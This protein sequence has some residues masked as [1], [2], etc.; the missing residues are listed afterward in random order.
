MGLGS[1]QAPRGRRNSPLRA[2]GLLVAGLGIAAC[3][4]GDVSTSIPD[5]SQVADTDRDASDV[6]ADNPKPGDGASDDGPLDA[7]E[8][9][10]IL[11]PGC[12]AT[13]TPAAAA[14]PLVWETCGAGCKR[15]R[16]DWSAKVER[17]FLSPAIDAI[18]MTELGPVF[19]QYR[20]N[21]SSA[22]SFVTFSVV[23]QRLDGPVLATASTTQDGCLLEATLGDS[24]WAIASLSPSTG[25]IGVARFGW[26]EPRIP[27][28]EAKTSQGALALGPAG[29]HD[30]IVL[31]SSV[32]F[33]VRD[34]EGVAELLADG[35][36]RK[37]ALP[38]ESAVAW[39]G[40]GAA[41]RLA[42]PLGVDT[43]KADGTVGES[44][45]PSV[46][47]RAIA[48]RVDRPADRLVWVEAQET[49]DG[50]LAPTLWVRE[51]STNRLVAPLN[52]GTGRGAGP[53]VVTNGL[54]VAPISDT[55]VQ[56]VR[57]SDGLGW[58]MSMPSG[59][60]AIEP[61]WIDDEDVWVVVGDIKLKNFR[62]YPQAILRLSRAA[63]GPAS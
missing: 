45:V 55:T 47:R 39:R 54:V 44:I 11:V 38:I 17:A 25:A 49:L 53:F 2:V 41:V 13:P 19:L 50:W 31:S 27:I 32:D 48:V 36:L 23:L 63:L 37:F 46:G 10:S 28:Q 16:S 61:L 3:H 35:S 33:I 9:A 43:W 42:E 1:A 58:T 52:D 24:G 30:D 20:T 14:A 59:L 29:Y 15:S 4:S 57:L 21:W 12:A 18:R 26:K 51:A 6:R 56:I 7:S 8:T 34:P 60:G 62:T 5:D 40:G 22:L